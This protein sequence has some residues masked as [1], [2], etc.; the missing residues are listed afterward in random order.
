MK[1]LYLPST[2]CNFNC[3]EDSIDIRTGVVPDTNRNGVNDECDPDPAVMES[4]RATY[5]LISMKAP[6][7]SVV[8]ASGRTL[9]IHYR[10]PK[11]AHSIRMFVI[12][13]HRHYPIRLEAPD[14]RGMGKVNWLPT[15]APPALGTAA[16]LVLEVDR[17][18]V[19]KPIAWGWVVQRSPSK[20]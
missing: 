16:E 2:D 15:L 4:A 8:Y 10:V 20:P 12:D 17:A 18:T 9:E 19:V 5:D 14:D 7:M 6:C 3:V 1:H 11:G 13:G